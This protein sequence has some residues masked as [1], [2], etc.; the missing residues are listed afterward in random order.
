MK[1]SKPAHL[2]KLE[3]L[4]NIKSGHLFGYLE[5]NPEGNVRVIQPKDIDDEGNIKK[6]GLYRVQ[7]DRITNSSLLKTDDLIFRAKGVN[8]LSSIVSQ[9]DGKLMVT[10]HFFILKLKSNLVD[11]EYL[12]WYLNHND[13]RR[14]FITKTGIALIPTITKKILEELEIP[15]PDKNTQK[16]IVEI[17]R[18]LKREKKI[19]DEIREKRFFMIQNL[20][21][22]AAQEQ[23]TL[24]G[25]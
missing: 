19:L 9:S 24:G 4:V 16:A 22:K 1:P 14:Y 15:V 18:L 20:L 8:P 7:L 13:A 17:D 11:T 21:I 6:Q 12:R 5:D 25:K 3:H 2:H 23:S 10:N